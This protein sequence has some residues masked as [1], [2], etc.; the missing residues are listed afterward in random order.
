MKKT[1]L[2]TCLFLSLVLSGCSSKAPANISAT[3]NI[4]LNVTAAVPISQNVTPD[5]NNSSTA[6]LTVGANFTGTATST[7]GVNAIQVSLKTDADMI[8]YVEQS[9]DGVN[10]DIV[11]HF[12][13]LWA[14]GGNSWTVQAVNSWERV[15]V[16]NNNGHNTTYFRLQT[17]LCPI[18]E[19]VPRALT[20]TGRFKTQTVITDD[21]GFDVEGTP[22]NALKVATQVKLAGGIFIGSTSNSVPDPNFWTVNNSFNGSSFIAANSATTGGELTLG[23]NTTANGSTRVSSQRRGRYVAG[24]PNF[25]HM[26]IHFPDIGTINNTRRWGVADYTNIQNITDG[27]YYSL[28]GTV[29]SINTMRG[30]SVTTVSSGNFNGNYGTVYHLDINNVHQYEIYYTTYAVYF[31]IDGKLLHTISASPMPWSNTQTL[32]LYMD[33][34]N[35]GGQTANVLM[36]VRSA[37]IQRLGQMLSAPK[38]IHIAANSTVVCK[39]SAGTLH[40]VIVNNPTNNAITLYDNTVASGAVI[41]VIL[42]LNNSSPFELHYDLD[43]STGLTIVT[44][45]NTDLTLIFE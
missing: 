44:G 43:F 11:D 26:T 34:T 40:A 23:T 38:Y 2:I 21:Y 1:L 7:L 45:A 33:N 35:I 41:A 36:H 10:W 30:G 16:V 5:P 29:F 28:N 42:P 8:V 37:S 25:A 13:Y 31:S 27:A 18:V 39:Y 20:D 17:V 14:L 19:A 15:V 24:T 9:P 32:Y 12:D 6:N 22:N 4:S 3:G